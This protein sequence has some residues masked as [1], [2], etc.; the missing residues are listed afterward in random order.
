MNDLSKSIHLNKEQVVKSGS[1][2]T[3][4][5][6]VDL[7]YNM[8]YEYI[9]EDSIIADFGAG[10][11][12]FLNK[13][14]H[15][16][17]RRIATEIDQFSYNFLKEN[18]LNCEIY[19]ENSLINVSRKK[20]K[21]LK[22]DKLIIIGNPPYN[23]VT[24]IYKKGNK[25]NIACDEDLI[26]RDLGICF[27]KAYYKL[28]ANYICVLHTLSYLI[29]KQNFNLLKEFKNNYKLI[30]GVIFSSKEFTTISKKN[31]DFPVVAALYE[32]DNNGMTYEYIKNFEFNIFKDSNTFKIK[33]ILTI[34]GIINKYPK[35]NNKTKIQFYTLRD[36]N[37]LM[38]NTTFFIGPKNNGINVDIDNLYQYSWL[39]FLKNNFNPPKNNFIYN[40]LS[41]LYF[42][43]LEN[44]KYKN[45]VVSYAYNNCKIL[46]ENINIEIIEKKYGK[47]TNNYQPL[48]Q[49]LKKLYII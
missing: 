25:G 11:G 10:Y 2:Y 9:N 29:K 49:I 42:N 8:I 30:K 6:L 4:N 27:L 14:T 19:C 5:Y 18:Y 32:K 13:F 15:L 34:D 7:V 33:N 21:I 37:S 17:K 41:P 28:N 44:Y 47:L 26:T 23:D 20:Y 43:E 36:M 38:R 12:A 48:Y 31:S 39:Y 45:L 16:G 35:K 40:N 46:N 22:K 24:S 3:P 1:I